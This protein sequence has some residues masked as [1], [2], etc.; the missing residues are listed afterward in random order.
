MAANNRSITIEVVRD[1]NM[2]QCREL[3]TELMDFQ[4][5]QA[6]FG[7]ELFEKMNFDTRMKKS[8]E[9]AQ[10]SHIVVARDGET[11]IGYVFSTIDSTEENRGGIPAWAPVKPGE[12]VMG[13]YPDWPN[14]PTKVGCLSNLYFRDTYRGLGLGTKLFGMA[15]EWLESFADVNLIFVY[16]SNGNDTALKFY[17]DHGF[18]YSHEVYGGFI[19]AAYKYKQ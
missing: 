8:Y 18:A 6:V 5:E 12:K 19:K 4:K 13:L 10:A 16:V 3:C 15:L 9:A 11:P 2:E 17:L 7:K 14:L 1:G